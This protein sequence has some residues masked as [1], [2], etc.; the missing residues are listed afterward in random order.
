MESSLHRLQS[1]L[2]VPHGQ[3]S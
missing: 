1:V 3:A 2:R